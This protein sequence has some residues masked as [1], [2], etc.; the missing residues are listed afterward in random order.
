MRLGLATRDQL[1]VPPSGADVNLPSLG[2]ASA[3][4]LLTR[5]REGT[6]SQAQGQRLDSQR[7][8]HTQA[9]CCPLSAQS[10][11]ACHTQCGPGAPGMQ[12]SVFMKPVLREEKKQSSKSSQRL[13]GSDEH[14]MENS[15]KM[16]LWSL[17]GREK[18]RT[19]GQ[20]SLLRCP[21][22]KWQVQRPRGWSV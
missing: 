15:R 14:C 8:V 2:A 1:L 3:Q 20:D 13:S 17:P 22:R 7:A 19:K 18:L 11:S 6:T 12:A 5:N 21:E 10:L 9:S 4:R 16:A